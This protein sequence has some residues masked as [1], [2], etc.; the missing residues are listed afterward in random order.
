MSKK[1]ILVRRQRRREFEE[2]VNIEFAIHRLLLCWD[3][4]SP[5]FLALDRLQKRRAMLAGNNYVRCRTVR[6][7]RKNGFFT[8]MVQWMSKNGRRRLA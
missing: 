1:S 8:G 4:E 2:L 7:L 5:Q 6:H 3:D